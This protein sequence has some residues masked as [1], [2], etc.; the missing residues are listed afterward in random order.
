MEDLAPSTGA[1]AAIIVSGRGRER[2][3]RHR[4]TQSRRTD[5]L[6]AFVL[7]AALLIYAL[8]P[9]LWLAALAS[10]GFV[11]AAFVRPRL[12]LA[13]VLATLPTY[14]HAPELA[15]LALSL[16]EVA[17]LLTTVG[18]AIRVAVRD[19]VRPRA[20]R[21]DGWVALLLAA[22]LL[23]LLPTEYLKL[24]LRLLRT[25]LLE[26]VFFYYLVVSLCPDLRALRPLAVGFLGAAAVVAA[27]A[28]G[29]VLVN[30][31]T[32]E[33]E[34]VRRALGPFPSPNHLGLYLGRALPFAVAGVLWSRRLRGICLGLSGLLATALALTFSVG[35]W[36]GAATSLLVL[37]ALAGR[38]ALVALSLAGGGLAA[39][40]LMVLARLGVERV[41]GQAT[42]GGTTAISR[43][44]IWA[45]ALAMLRDHPILGIG[46]DNFLYRYQLEYMLP[47]AWAEPNISHPHN[48]VLQ[49]WL[50]LG[51]PGLL[52]VLGL[53][54]TF[55]WCTARLLR[56][57]AGD[58]AGR[59]PRPRCFRSPLVVGALASVAGWLV[60]GAVDNSY[61]LVD[62]AY[63]FWWQLAI[64]EIAARGA[65]ML[66]GHASVENPAANSDSRP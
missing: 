10:A 63:L 40:A 52:A 18:L 26:P 20:T 53:L 5:A 28:I 4:V 11:I 2:A 13:A 65:S 31:Q 46:L 38:R 8:A 59:L 9:A 62:Q 27:L 43:R 54:G 19:D 32:V 33:A 15:G 39:L 44:L 47:E 45:A 34:G 50:E 57:S 60:H 37:A 22:A 55:F 12:G 61:F 35:A 23:S 58:S 6:S 21:S 17:L 42:L 41:I 56:R 66:D 64:V 24:S 51:V 36:L 7:A 16:P 29:Q 49:F 1:P 14:F 3:R 48:W 30:T 25:L